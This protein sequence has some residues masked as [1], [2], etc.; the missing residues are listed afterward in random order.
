MSWTGVDCTVMD[1]LVLY[2]AVPE[3]GV[4]G[5]VWWCFRRSEE[6]GGQRSKAD[7]RHGWFHLKAHRHIHACMCT[8]ICITNWKGCSITMFCTF[9][10]SQADMQ[11][12]KYCR[13][14]NKSFYWT[15]QWHIT[16]RFPESRHKCFSLYTLWM[17]KISNKTENFSQKFA[18][19]WYW[20]NGLC[21]HNWKCTDQ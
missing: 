10:F 2:F 7:E 3:E 21:P 12:C 17:R 8:H 14:E 1:W 5:R 9:P 11:I 19:S 15:H 13:G 4:R 20:S 18:L 16:C 6:P